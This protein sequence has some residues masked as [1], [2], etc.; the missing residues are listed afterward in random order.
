MS[1]EPSKRP[2]LTRGEIKDGNL[3]KLRLW[4]TGLLLAVG[5]GYVAATGMAS[6]YPALKVVA[7]FCEAAMIG[8][9]ADWFAV[10]AL[11]RHPLGLPL[12][13]TAILPRNKRRIAAG[14]SEFI[15]NNFLSAQAIVAKIGEIGPA[16]KLRQWLLNRENTQTVATY[17]TR[18]LSFALTAFDD[19]RVRAF[20]HGAVT[21]KLRQV[22]FASGV[23]HLLDAMT[24]GRR[25]QAVLDEVLRLL[26][27][28][29]AR[30]ETRAALARAVAAESWLVEITKKL[31]FDLDETIARKMVSGAAKL[32]EEVRNDESHAMRT[33]FDSF[34]AQY[35]EKLKGD[36]DTRAKV[37][38][39]LDE[40]LRN[41]ALLGYIDS[42]WQEFRS[43]LGSDL[44]DA[45]S[46]VHGALAAMVA[47]L[48]E[49]IDATPGLSSWIDEQILKSV[50]PLVEQNKA[51][52]GRFIEDRINEWRDERF[53]KELER[54]IGPDLQ[55]IRINGTIVGGLAGLL[56]YVLTHAT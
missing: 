24:H 22:D 35:I 44:A 4:A 41:P 43:W 13:H 5:V 16:E 7:A 6:T 28:A 36:P 51:K 34:M 20:L 25:H 33:Q 48:G 55:Y 26:D 17:V 29:L 52:I 21:S 50:P 53:V 2:A 40:M 54:E 56:I 47:T 37:R 42:L 49:N 27:D 9:L 15:Q 39:L 3:R 45:N 12:P 18:L 30:A 38:E 19:A 10:V 14:I 1:R 32:V 46:R 11:F 8:A 31:G 23:G